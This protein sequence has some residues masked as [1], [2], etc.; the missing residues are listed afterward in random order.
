[1]E[2]TEDYGFSKT[3]N[4]EKLKTWSEIPPTDIH[5]LDTIVKLQEK[6]HEQSPFP[7]DSVLNRKIVLW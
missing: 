4:A 7:Y 5:D 3:V 6:C 1:M 2:A